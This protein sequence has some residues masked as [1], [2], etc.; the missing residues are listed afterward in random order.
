MRFS[1]FDPQLGGLRRIT[2]MDGIGSSIEGKPD[3]TSW[4]FYVINNTNNTFWCVFG[5]LAPDCDKSTTAN[6]PLFYFQAIKNEKV[7]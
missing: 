2:C 5:C 1:I 3:V 7:I 4:T 6:V